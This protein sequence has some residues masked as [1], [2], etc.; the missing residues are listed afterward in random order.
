MIV[1]TDGVCMDPAK[2]KVIV[3]WVAPKSVEEIQSFSGFANFYCIFIFKF[4]KLAGLLTSLEHKIAVWKWTAIEQ[5]HFE[6]LKAEFV[7][8]PILAYFDPDK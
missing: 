3:E 7:K 2:I 6:R 5:D 8:T 1:T 4:S